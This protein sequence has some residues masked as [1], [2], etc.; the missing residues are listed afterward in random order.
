MFSAQ[1]N[2]K[3]M[4]PGLGTGLLRMLSCVWVGGWVDVWVGVGGW[5][6]GWVCEWVAVCLSVC[7]HRVRGDQALRWHPKKLR[8]L[9]T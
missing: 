7:L 3:K 4:F 9:C 6:D 2:L 5:V 1:E 8:V